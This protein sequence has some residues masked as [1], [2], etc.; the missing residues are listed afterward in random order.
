MNTYYNQVQGKQ[1][2]LKRSP[3]ENQEGTDNPEGKAYP[4]AG[5]Q[6]SA[7]TVRALPCNYIISK[8]LTVSLDWSE[9]LVRA[10]LLEHTLTGT[11]NLS[12][13]LPHLGSLGSHV[14][15]LWE[16]R[17]PVFV[18]FTAQI[19][20][21]FNCWALS[22]NYELPESMDCSPWGPWGENAVDKW[23]EVEEASEYMWFFQEL[24]LDEARLH[25][26]VV[27]AVTERH[28][29]RYRAAA[30][31]DA[32]LST[33]RLDVLSRWSSWHRGESRK[34]QGPITAPTLL[35]RHP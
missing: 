30:Q 13:R 15:L 10:R 14:H 6:D 9:N 1:G 5:K 2:L 31:R 21:H 32:S 19:P 27:C 8:R 29:E 4:P 26:N 24:G 11:L 33:R 22:T 28:T 25:Y 7:E 18:Y 34:G 12:S 16:S 3:V 23:M 17:H 35:G 20:L